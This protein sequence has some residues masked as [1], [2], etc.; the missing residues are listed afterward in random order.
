M[1]LITDFSLFCPQPNRPE[2]MGI[3]KL[4]DALKYCIIKLR[5][6]ASCRSSSDVLEVSLIT[7]SFLPFVLFCIIDTF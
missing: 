5:R 6:G 3:M 2:V 4:V 1:L 7:F